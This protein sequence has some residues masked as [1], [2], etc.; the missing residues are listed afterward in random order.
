MRTIPDSLFKENWADLSDQE[1]RL[2]AAY[3]VATLLYPPA[4]E[5]EG[6][7]WRRRKAVHALWA[8]HVISEVDTLLAAIVKGDLVSDMDHVQALAAPLAAYWHDNWVDTL[9]R[10]GS[11]NFYNHKKLKKVWPKWVNLYL[12]ASALIRLRDHHADDANGGEPGLRQANWLVLKTYPRG[13]GYVRSA[14]GLESVAQSEKAVWPLVCGVMHCLVRQHL[15]KEQRNASAPPSLQSLVSFEMPTTRKIVRTI[16]KQP[17]RVLRA[18]S[19][20]MAELA[21]PV[22]RRA[23]PLLAQSDCVELP[24]YSDFKGAL[25]LPAYL[26]KLADSE[27][28]V[29]KSFDSKEYNLL[30]SQAIKLPHSPK[31]KAG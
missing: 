12:V 2:F 3:V 7:A 6:Q 23:H 25:S 22:S 27:I 24:Q 1:R 31:A 29:A 17:E 14:K 8:K 15:P 26:G 10:A 21:R 30:K 13:C 16:R 4:T 20:F 5:E 9:R 28:K 11:P 18:T 19:F